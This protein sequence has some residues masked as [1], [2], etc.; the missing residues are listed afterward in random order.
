MEGNNKGKTGIL[1]RNVCF[2]VI[3]EFICTAKQIVI[4][5]FDIVYALF[6]V[7]FPLWLAGYSGIEN[8]WIQLSFW[9]CGL[10]FLMFVREVFR[11]IRNVTKSKIPVYSRRF[12]FVDESGILCVEH[13][14]IPE[15]IS[16]L[17]DIE[18]YLESK[19]LLKNNA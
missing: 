9:I 4:K 12:T 7:F 11:K 3:N 2:V 5:N 8:D 6:V 17:A 13:D 18:D 16:Y 15:I 19:G 1:K 14:D 10:L